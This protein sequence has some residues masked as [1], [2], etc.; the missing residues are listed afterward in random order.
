MEQKNKEKKDKKIY[1]LKDESQFT[2]YK[3]G[4]IFVVDGPAVQRVMRRVNVEDN[5]SLHYFHKCLDDLRVNQAL[6]KAG[7]Q[8]G[9][10]VRVVD[11]ELEWY[12]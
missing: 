10:T 12:D 6:K 9:D 4:K 2:I 5:E 11:W 7:V 3:E 1:E 8:E